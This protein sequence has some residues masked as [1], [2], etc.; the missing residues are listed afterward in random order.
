PLRS[1]RSDELADLDRGG[2][3]L[4]HLRCAL[5]R[6]LPEPAV[7]FL[8]R[9]RYRLLLAYH[10]KTPQPAA[11]LAPSKFEPP[12]P[13]PVAQAD[14]LEVRTSAPAVSEG[15]TSSSP[16]CAGKHGHA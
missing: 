3:A 15:T 10:N 12:R 1:S 7:T 16:S 2:D 14:A 11:P 5:L 13:F 6:P 8:S 4:W 9:L